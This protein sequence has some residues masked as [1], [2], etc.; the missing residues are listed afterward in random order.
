MRRA[1][2]EGVEVCAIATETPFGEFWMHWR[3]FLGGRGAAPS[4]VAALER[5]ARQQLR[6]ALR[7]RL[8][9]AADGSIQLAAIA[10]AVSVQLRGHA[11]KRGRCESPV[12]NPRMKVIGS[13]R[14]PRQRGTSDGNSQGSAG[15]GGVY[16]R[17]SFDPR[18]LLARPQ[19]P[20][21]PERGVALGAALVARA[22]P[23]IVG[24]A[25]PTPDDPSKVLGGPLR[26]CG[27]R[28]LFEPQVGRHSRRRRA[29]RQLHALDETL[30]SSRR[31]PYA[32]WC[33]PTLPTASSA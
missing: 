1:G 11:R 5:R 32:S 10:W 28:S 8:P 14:A 21:V 29:R 3:P 16:D 18:I 33:S 19:P 31:A 30:G 13:R 7:Q 26:P 24:Q 15:Q 2:L 20:P 27:E 23:P 22:W 12:D 25:Q 6:E 17:S 4:Y 9:V